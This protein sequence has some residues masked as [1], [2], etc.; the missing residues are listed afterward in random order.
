[1]GPATPGVPTTAAAPAAPADPGDSGGGHCDGRGAAAK[2]R[3][4][5]GEQFGEP[6]GLG[7][8][9]VGACV[10]ADDGV[11]LVGA[12]SQHQH[13]QDRETLPQ[14]TANLQPVHTGQAEIQHNQV[15]PA[16]CGGVQ[17]FTERGGP[18]GDENDL[19][20]LA[21][22]R[23]LKRSGDRRIILGKEQLPHDRAAYGAGGLLSRQRVSDAAPPRPVPVGGRT[24]PVPE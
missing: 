11:E 19:I 12:G 21:P 13:G 6:E 1:M 22:Q 5:A 20:S 4:Q 16:G 24:G 10:E 7:Q 14:A 17:S 9:V 3:P 23:A 18:V 8:V 15:E 2:Q